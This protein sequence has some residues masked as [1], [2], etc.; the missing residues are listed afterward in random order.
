[1]LLLCETNSAFFITAQS[2]QKQSLLPTETMFHLSI[3]K[4]TKNRCTDSVL[5][6]GVA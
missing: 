2:L 3:T 5:D 1:M 6:L 4:P